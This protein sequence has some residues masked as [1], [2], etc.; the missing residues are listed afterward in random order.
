VKEKKMST[1]NQQSRTKG[2]SGV[3]FVACFMISL[4]VGLYTGQMAIAVLGGLGVS[5][6]ALAIT[7]YV[8]GEW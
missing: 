8:T 6:I 2:I 5:F 7:R 3:V 1:Q 4:A